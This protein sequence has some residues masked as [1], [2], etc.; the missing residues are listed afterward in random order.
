MGE[1]VRVLDVI[2]SPSRPEACEFVQASVLD[3]KAVRDAVEGVDF[4][5]HTAALVPLTK[6]GAHFR[7]VNVEGTRILAEAALAAGVQ[8]FVHTSSSAVF[9][10]PRGPVA[11]GTPLRPIE[12]YGR[13]KADAEMCLKE[14]QSRGLACAVIRPRTVI[15]PGR[16]GIFQILFE[17]MREGRALY[18]IGNGRNLLQF[19][20]VSDL[21]A[22]SLLCIRK[23]RPG[24]YNVGAARFGTLRDDLRSVIRH[25]GSRSRIVGL[26]VNATMATL[27]A[28]DRLRLSPL[29]PW[30]YLTYHK[31]FHFDITPLT[32]DLGWKPAYGNVDMMIE[33]YEWFLRHREQSAQDNAGST[34]RSRVKQGVLG[35]VKRFS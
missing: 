3:R 2:D 13:S 24:M 12:T 27:K 14:V 5:H 10:V 15:G 19:L 34:H 35:L 6:A 30:H 29:A 31:P 26:P 1:R 21:V 9:G 33:A 23:D 18:V 22:V 7:E 16:L 17:W 32:Q 11:E 8:M 20:H 4:V 25:A 28:L